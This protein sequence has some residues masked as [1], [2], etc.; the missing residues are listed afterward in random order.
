MYYDIFEMELVGDCAFQ[1]PDQ[2]CGLRIVCF[3]LFLF[4]TTD[5]G[6]AGIKKLAGIMCLSS[7]RSQLFSC[8]SMVL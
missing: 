5:S 8:V 2:M 3:S 7:I 4:L 6:C 1:G